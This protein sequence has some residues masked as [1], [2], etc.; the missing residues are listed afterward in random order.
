MSA[1]VHRIRQFSRIL[2]ESL[3]FEMVLLA[4][5]QCTWNQFWWVTGKMLEQGGFEK[6]PAGTYCRIS[7][8]TFGNICGGTNARFRPSNIKFTLVYLS[9]PTREFLKTVL[10]KMKDTLDWANRTPNPSYRQTLERV[11]N[12]AGSI[13]EI[14][15]FRAQLFSPLCTLSGL[16]SPGSASD[17]AFPTVG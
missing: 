9:D 13:P 16:C 7:M 17:F 4:L 12:L 15:I 8:E 10:C 6:E 1:A 11:T 14:G 2:S 3:L 5:Y